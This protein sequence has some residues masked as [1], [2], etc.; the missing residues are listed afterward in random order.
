[1]FFIKQ[2]DAH[3][4]T[5]LHGKT[6]GRLQRL[7][8]SPLGLWVIAAISFFE[9]ALPVPLVTDPFMVAGILA[10]RSRATL[11]VVVTTI[12]SIIGG[13]AA[14]LLASFFFSV[15][16]QYMTPDMQADF[17]SLVSFGASD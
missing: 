3:I 11:I 1:M 8:Q 6:A 14:F 2:I 12:S 15:I 9:S 13:L 4:A 17:A 5:V 7:L 16:A 10:N